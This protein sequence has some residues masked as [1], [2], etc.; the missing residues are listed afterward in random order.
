MTGHK[1]TY[2]V[3]YARRSCR[4]LELAESGV[5]EV[6]RADYVQVASY[7]SVGLEARIELEM[8]DDFYGESLLLN[9]HPDIHAHLR[10]LIRGGETDHMSFDAGDIVVGPS[11]GALM[12]LPVIG[13]RPVTIREHF[14]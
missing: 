5:T 7:E 9:T 13:W 10:G 1:G 2:T 3:L 8:Q 6:S 11:G 14:R 4:G 12:R